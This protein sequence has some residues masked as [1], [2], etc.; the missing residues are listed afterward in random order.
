MQL[1]GCV[2]HLHGRA[3]HIEHN[4]PRGFLLE[5]L[6]LRDTKTL[7][8]IVSYCRFCAF[9]QIFNICDKTQSR[10]LTRNQ[11]VARQLLILLDTS[12]YL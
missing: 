6:K 10:E 3:M 8:R 4:T 2:V 7:H 1:L 5:T 11:N 12:K 9:Y